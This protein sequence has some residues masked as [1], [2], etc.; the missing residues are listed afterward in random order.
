MVAT[1]IFF[2]PAWGKQK[3][4]VSKDMDFIVKRRDNLI[5]LADKYKGNITPAK[6]MEIMATPLEEGGSFRAPNFT[7]YQYVAQPSTLKMWLRVPEY[8]D[9]TEVNLA[10]FF[11]K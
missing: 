7:S 1:N 10:L 6:M 3:Y 11:N 8:Q 2:D 4:D 9:W 5:A